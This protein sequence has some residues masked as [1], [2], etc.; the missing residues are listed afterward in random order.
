MLIQTAYTTTT[1]G[2]PFLAYCPRCKD[3]VRFEGGQ[4]SLVVCNCTV[5]RWGFP[6]NVLKIATIR[7]KV[8]AHKC[9]AKCTHAKGG[10]CECSCGGANHG[11]GWS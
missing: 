10:D 3:R 6:N 1:T 7:G 9:A 2:T 11:K 4:P 8:S 5:A